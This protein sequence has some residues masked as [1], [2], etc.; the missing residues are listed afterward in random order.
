M[1]GPSVPTVGPSYPCFSFCSKEGL[2][3]EGQQEIS[4]QE[5]GL[6]L[7][8]HLALGTE[9]ETPM[10]AAALVTTVFLTGSQPVPDPCLSAPCQNGGTC[11]DAD[12]GYVCEC[13]EGFMGLDC[14]DSACGRAGASRGVCM[15]TAG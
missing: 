2:L 7:K 10:C 11:V 9:V 14:R 15:Q 12:E 4:S 5:I 3:G 8:L 13:P 6:R 1:L